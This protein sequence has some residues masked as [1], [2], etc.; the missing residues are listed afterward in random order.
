MAFAAAK[1]FMIQVHDSSQHSFSIFNL[2]RNHEDYDIGKVQDY[3]EKN[4]DES[5]DDKRAG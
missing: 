3:I 4:Y 2:Q 5:A 1:V